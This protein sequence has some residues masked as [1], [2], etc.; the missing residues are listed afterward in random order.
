MLQAISWK[1]YFIL[2]G[3]GV[4]FYYGWWL[5]RY[6]PGLSAGRPGVAGQKDGRAQEAGNAGAGKEVVGA[7]PV[8]VAEKEEEG[9]ARQLELPLPAV[10]E[11]PVFLPE[12]AARLIEE[13][14]RLFGKAKMEGIVEGEL[15]YM[16]QRL[17]AKEPNKKL[18]GTPYEEKMNALLA[19]ELERYGSVRPDAEVVK[20]LWC[21]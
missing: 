12:V 7:A 2:V 4:G 15:I 11:K 8:M 9:A 19:R 16:L 20:G 18:R 14:V 1:E 6:Y 17:L 3:L 13:V 5:V 21:G 10:I